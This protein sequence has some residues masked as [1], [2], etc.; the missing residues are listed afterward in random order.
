MK[1]RRSGDSRE[2]E[3][4]ILARDGARVRALIAGRE[5][6]ATVE[7]TP[8]GAATITIGERRYRAAAVKTRAGAFVAIGPRT[9]ELSAVEEGARR[10]G[11]GLAAPEIAAPMPGKVLKVMVKEGQAVE[12]GPPLVVIDAMMMETTLAAESDAIIKRIRVSAGQMVDHGAVLIELSPA[13]DSSERQSGPQA[14]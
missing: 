7:P 1:L 11:H 4:E 9:F 12:A 6:D 3:V 13:A 8:D 14:S 2:H 5:V 10:H